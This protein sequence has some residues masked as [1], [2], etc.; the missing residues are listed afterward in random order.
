MQHDYSHYYVLAIIVV[1]VIAPISEETIFRGFIY[2]WLHRWG[3]ALL[4][5]PLSAVIFAAVHQ[6]LVLFLPLFF[7]GVVLASL[8]QGSRSIIPGILTH[9]LF[10]LP[11]IIAIL[12]TTTTC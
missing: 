6:Q 9:A 10:N 4:A 1:C 2:G 8:Y 3:P 5:I 11:N 7:V 12:S